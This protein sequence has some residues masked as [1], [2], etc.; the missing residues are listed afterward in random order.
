[1]DWV[2]LRSRGKEL[3]KKYRYVL[4]VVL[5]G[6]FLMALPD[7]K[8]AN[9]APEPAA[10]TEP[11]QNL[12]TDLEEILSQIQGAGRVRVLLTQ[13]EGEQTVYQTDEDSTSSG[14]RSDTVLLSGADRSQTGL[15]Q[16]VNPPTY[17]GAVIVCQGADSASVR[18]AIVSAVGSVTGLST[19]KITV[20]KLKEPLN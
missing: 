16:Q 1:M 6:L 15:V 14:V 4:L 7:G 5:A 12:Q 2:T 10:E 11:G 20:L 8:N 18:L 19:D 3:V 17:L 13:R 9:A